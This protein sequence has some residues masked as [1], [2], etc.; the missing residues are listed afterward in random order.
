MIDNLPTLHASAEPTSP[1][2]TITRSYS[3]PP[4]LTEELHSLLL[5]GWRNGV[6]NRCRAAATA[7]AT[8][9]EGEDVMMCVRARELC[10][11]L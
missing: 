11:N 1:P 7:I 5:A 2:P 6:D 9:T 4:L 10:F 8:F 3:S